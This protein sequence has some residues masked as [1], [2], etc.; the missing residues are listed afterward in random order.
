M[1]NE[2]SE[3]KQITNADTLR[4]YELEN[5]QKYYQLFDSYSNHFKKAMSIK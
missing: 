3:I 2:V 4:R 1:Y 5:M